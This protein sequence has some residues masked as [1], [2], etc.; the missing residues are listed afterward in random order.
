MN[1]LTTLKTKTQEG[2]QRLLDTA[3][4]QPP[5][6]QKWSIVAAS[7]VAGGLVVAASAKSVLTIVS[8]IAAPPVALSVGA[9]AGGVL[10]WRYRQGKLQ[11]AGAPSTTTPET[12]G[13]ETPGDLGVATASAS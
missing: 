2:W 13:P 6:V 7:A 10:G 11:P 12:L 8:V 4:Q 5:E 9:V 3:Q 1:N